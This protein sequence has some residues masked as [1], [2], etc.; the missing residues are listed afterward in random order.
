RVRSPVKNASFSR[1]TIMQRPIHLNN[2]TAYTLA[3]PGKRLMRLAVALVV[4]IVSCGS[5]TAQPPDAQTH[6][7]Q[8][9][10]LRESRGHL[11]PMRDGVKLSVDVYRPDAQGRYPAIL[12]HTPYNNNS[13]LWT[14]RA[15]GF[16]KRGYVVAI[17]DCRGRFDSEGEWDPFGA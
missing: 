17:S 5:V 7:P 13:S 1:T 12:I 15:R 16:A 4:A 14:E 3:N 9:Y 10:T 11:S 8:K 2:A 6:S